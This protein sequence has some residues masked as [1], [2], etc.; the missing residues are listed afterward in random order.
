MQQIR[1]RILLIENNDEHRL[2]IASWLSRQ[3][4]RVHEVATGH[5]ALDKIKN[6]MRF[7][8]V[9]CD[10]KLPGLSGVD[11]LNQLRAAGET[12][13]FILMARPADKKAIATAL[14]K[15]SCHVLLKPVVQEAF[16]QQ[17]AQALLPEM[18][19][20]AKAA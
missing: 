4:Y 19:N 16:L 1:S 17:I 8:A 18:A 13:P 10:F 7:D 12:L 11:V 20:E 2:R 5:Q 3:G 9:V 14:R 15:R 6:G